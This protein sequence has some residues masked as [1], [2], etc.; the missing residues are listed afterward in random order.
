MINLPDA[1]NGVFE[2]GGAAVNLLNIK[3]IVRD[4]EVRGINSWV[5]VWFSTWGLYNLYYYPHLGQWLSFAGGAAIVAVNCSWLGL[6]V[7][8][9]K[10]NNELGRGTCQT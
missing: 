5:Y 9:W 2:L 8:Y 1:V 4:K 7:Y 10:K 6:A 3:A